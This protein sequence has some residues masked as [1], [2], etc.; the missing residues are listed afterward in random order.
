MSTSATGAPVS[1]ERFSSEKPI[2][3]LWLIKGLGRGGAE[4]LLYHAA[5]LRDRESFTVGLGYLLK[6]RSWLA[7]DF[8]AEGV[9]VRLFPAERNADIRWALKL[10]RYLRNSPVD[11]VHVHSPLVAAVTRVVVRTLPRSQRPRT[12]STEHLPWSGHARATRFVNAATFRLDDAHLAVSDAVLESIP[13]R[14]RKEVRVLVHGVPVDVIRT[15]RKER[16]AVRAEFGVAPDEVLVGTV[17]NVTPQ[18][19]YPDLLAAAKMLVDR[20]RRVRFAVAGRGTEELGAIGEK[21]GLGDSLLVIGPLDD[22]PRFMA[23]C[24]IF[25]LA[26]HWEGLPLVLME[27]MAVGIPIVA[28]RVGGIPEL[29]RHTLEGLLVPHGRPELFAQALDE[30]VADPGRRERMGLAGMERSMRFDN[31]EAV[32]SIEALY[33]EVVGRRNGRKGKK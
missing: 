25:A 28:T 5:R 13:R 18:K 11:I 26:S 19:G 8:S 32:R 3:V 6:S 9:P 17:A 16:E 14:H 30:L 4:M 1:F 10:R 24:D 15:K 7:D 23:G 33:R 22:A 12:I 20:G 29:A 27:A 2:R 21:L 31:R